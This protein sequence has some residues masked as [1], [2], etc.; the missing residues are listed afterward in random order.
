MKNLSKKILGSIIAI[1]ILLSTN[2]SIAATE[3]QL[4]DQK[5]DNNQKIEDAQEAQEQVQQ[6]K[7]TAMEEVNNLNEQISNYQSQINSLDSQIDEANQKIEEETNKLD[8]AQA[9]YDEQQEIF[10]TRVVALYEMGETTY[11]DY[12]LSA[13]S[14]TEFLSTYYIMSEIAEADTNMLEEIDN[15]KKE[16]EQAK[17]ELENSKKELTTARAD[18]ERVA[19][20]LESTKEQKDQY[21]A[22]L[23]QDEQNLQQQIEELRQ[24]NI[25][26]D[27]D[28]SAARA[29]AQRILEEQKRKEQEEANKGNNSGSSNNGGTSNSSS[30]G[31]IY[32]V[33]SAYSRI[34]TG[35]YYSSGAYHGAVDFGSSGIN[36]QPVYAVADGI[37]VTAK[38]LTT[39]Y[40]N[41][42]I[43]L[44]D[45]GL[46]TLYAHG[47]AG[48]IAVSQYERVKQGQ[49]IMRVGSTGNSTGPHLHFEVR[50]G[51]GAYNNR[52]DPR[53]YLP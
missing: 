15:Q 36:G 51:N 46:Y 13:N 24:A 48:S 38:A 22:Q 11:L 44:H 28:I 45:N 37:V 39:S 8:E 43:I 41:Y 42:I 3:S 12:L 4:N 53:R 35:L 1:L 19:E 25:Q 6:A 50:T 18:K 27:K 29:E 49:Q 21:V 23:S 16:I 9:K 7:S 5:E 30:S 20:E 33:P 52:V 10:N 26:I 14:I 47:Q 17:T 34:T 40:G 2:L 32:P 31:F